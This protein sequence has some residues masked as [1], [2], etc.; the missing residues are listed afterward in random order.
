MTVAGTRGSAVVKPAVFLDRD[1]TLIEERGYLDRLDLIAPFPWASGALRRLRDAGLCAGA[2]DQPGGRRARVS[3]TKRSCTRRTA[4]WRR[5]WRLTAWC[6]TDTITARTIP[7]A[8]WRG[9]GAPADAGSQAREWWSRP[10]LIWTST[11][12]ARSSSATSGSTWSWR[13]NAG[14]RGILVRT[15]TA[16]APKAPRRRACLFTDRRT[17]SLTRLDLILKAPAPG[18]SVDH[19]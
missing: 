18:Q 5:C 13:A 1:G 3:S 4:I 14:A 19:D 6:S 17:R 15:A 9:I 8:P 16:R 7:R 2:G 11:W 10:P 12:R